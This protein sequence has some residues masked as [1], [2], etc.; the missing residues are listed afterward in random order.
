MTLTVE[1]AK[2]QTASFTDQDIWFKV[3]KFPNAICSDVQYEFMEKDCLFPSTA[4]QNLNDLESTLSDGFYFAKLV[5][6]DF[7]S[8][9]EFCLKV[10]NQVSSV[11]IPGLELEVYPNCTQALSNVESFSKSIN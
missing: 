1:M 5:K 9:I 7:P 2:K 8:K 11:T 6:L 4:F 10:S 3:P